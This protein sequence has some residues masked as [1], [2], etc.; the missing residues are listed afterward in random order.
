MKRH[1]INY[2][3]E[4]GQPITG[5]EVNIKVEEQAELDDEIND[6]IPAEP[7][8]PSRYIDRDSSWLEFNKRVLA[9]AKDKSNPL[10]ERLMFLGITA[11]NLDEFNM[12]RIGG[13][14]S[15]QNDFELRK[16]VKACNTFISE[17]YIIYNSL[18][19]EL[20]ENGIVIIS[21]TSVLTSKQLK[22]IHKYFMDNIYKILT[23]LAADDSRPFPS[24]KNKELVVAAVV[25]NPTNK[26]NVL[27]IVKMPTILDRL[28][29][30]SSED[31]N[32]V[33]ILLEDA[34]TLNLHELFEGM[35]VNNS[36]TCR[37]LRNA[38]IELN[39]IR[40]E[41]VLVTAMQKNL[42]TRET[43][44]LVR[45]DI[46]NN[47]KKGKKNI[48]G[49][50]KDF[51]KLQNKF[52]VDQYSIIDLSYLKSISKFI[53]FPE[54]MKFE[55][56]KPQE[57]IEFDTVDIFDSISKNDILVHHP[58]ES[59][60]D[61]VSRLI[62]ASANDPDVISIKQ[63]LY[64]VSSDSPIAKAL[65]YAAEKGK[66]VTVLLEIKARFDEQNNIDWYNELYQSGVNVVP[67]IPNLKAHCK[68]CL[69]TRVENGKFKS[70]AHLGTGNYHNAN[71]KIYEDLSLFT[72]DTKICEDMNRIFNILSGTSIGSKLKSLYYSP[73]NL[74]HRLYKMIDREITNIQ[75]GKKAWMVVKVNNLVDKDMIEKLYEASNAGVKITLIIRGSC[76][77]IPGV[78][79]MSENIIVQ[80][81]IGRYLEHS[82]IIAFAND[83]KPEYF[84]SSADWMDRNFN[85]RIEVLVPI[86]SKSNVKR[87]RDILSVY[88]TDTNRTW[89]MNQDGSY[90]KCEDTEGIDVQETLMRTQKQ[91][92]EL[93]NIVP[94]KSK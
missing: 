26:R 88:L 8:E 61:S 18:M 39:E 6:E 10:S 64:R 83:E 55:K 62:T 45:L 28:I 90:T 27:N 11:S 35:R 22:E 42:Q 74:R 93:Y 66:Q 81:V 13:R 78:V 80:S 33:F 34:I 48:R 53:D 30:I 57:I 40:N 1:N 50:L 70:Y 24:L 51:Y 9:E 82:R 31:S 29:P 86:E 36:A 63:T 91:T 72:T 79:G 54:E 52:I 75:A 2:N 5:S 46:D 89:F 17:Q 32:K 59:F 47:T 20:K 43:S 84:I 76:S 67:G 69:V 44:N 71:A 73:Y 68:L 77:L 14:S 21:D 23:P 56:Y 15:D 87:I 49:L 85:N 4:L 3:V 7:T 41:D 94:I 60:D 12:V 16:I 19:D 25:E 58:Y 38:N 92:T 37:L 65:K